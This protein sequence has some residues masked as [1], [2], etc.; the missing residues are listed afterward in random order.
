M[1]GEELREVFV[2]FPGV[3]GDRAYAFRSST[4]RKGLPFLTAREQEQMLR[5]HPTYRNAGRMVMP[6]NL[7]DAEALGSGTTPLYADRAD[8]TV[9][10]KTPSGEVLPVDEPRLVDLLRE[11]VRPSPDLSVWQSERALTDCRPVSLISMQ[12]VRQLSRE[13]GLELDRRRFRA[14]IY[15]DLEEE[16]GFSE[17]QW[18]ER[19]LRIG[20]RVE[21][22]VLA[23]DARCKI[24]T[25]DPNTGHSS[26]EVLRC[27]AQRHDA[28]AGVYAAVLVEGVVR[29]G[30]ALVPLDEPTPAGRGQD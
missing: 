22:A 19:R 18:V 25:L 11:G 9:D 17:D 24:I 20:S 15:V 2:G 28:K 16:A 3:Y 10:V 21:I 14:N 8:W 23:R 13:V 4:A 30:D 7:A 12:T 26:P 6:P 29:T 1:G 27:V 5:Y